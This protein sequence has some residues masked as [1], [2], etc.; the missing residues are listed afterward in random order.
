MDF[1]HVSMD[2]VQEQPEQKVIHF[3]SKKILIIKP[4]LNAKMKTKNF[5]WQIFIV[6]EWE[7]VVLGNVGE[8]LE[9]KKTLSI[10]SYS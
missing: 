10:V 2:Y 9:H 8:K 4:A 1:E 3:I 7:L 6:T 5:K